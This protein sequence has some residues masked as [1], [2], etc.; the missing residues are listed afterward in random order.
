M[1]WR[2]SDAP[3]VLADVGDNP[4][5]GGGG[6]TVDLL[7]ALLA[8]QAQGVLLAVFTD[9]AL[10]QEAHAL[11]G[12]AAF[13]AHF[14]RTEQLPFAQTFKHAAKVL[15]LS[16]GHFVGRRGLLHGSPS[17]MGLSALLEMGGVRVVVISLRQQLVDPAQLDALGIDLASVRTLVAKSRGHYRAAL[18]GFTLTERMIDVDGPGLT[19][20]N[21]KSL[22]WTRMPRPVH[23]MD[24]DTQGSWSATVDV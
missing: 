14:N 9:P 2:A 20:P 13:E 4:G 5:G 21:L 23:P 19:T 15:A 11:G 12:G 8:A 18:E 10:A 17:S 16:D 7:K 6:N 22:P 1:H 24:E 3:W